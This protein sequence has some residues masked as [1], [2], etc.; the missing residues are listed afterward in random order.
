MAYKIR[1]ADYFYAVIDDHPGEAYELLSQLASLGVNLIAV[2]ALPTGPMRTQLTLF[3]QDAAMMKNA[4]Q[5]AGISLDGP[6]R[7]LLVQGDDEIGV[8]SRLHSRLHQAS[9]DVYA[10]T[11]VTDG[12]GG[13]GCIVYVRPEHFEKAAQALEV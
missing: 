4:A 7:A 13:Y 10:S 2:N 9:V 8:L 11:G 1:R 3:P 5:K 6:H 12:R